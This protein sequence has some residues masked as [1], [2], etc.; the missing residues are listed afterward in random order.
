M[1][2]MK[3]AIIGT[4]L[5]LYSL[6]L[7]PAVIEISDLIISPAYIVAATSM[8]IP[9]FVISLWVISGYLAFI[10]GAGLLGHSIFRRLPAI[11]A[12]VKNPIALVFLVAF[13]ALVVCLAVIGVI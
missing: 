2:I 13:I 11:T 9:A 4:I 7:T 5:I 12:S 1:R 10:A 3:H 8:G 6:F